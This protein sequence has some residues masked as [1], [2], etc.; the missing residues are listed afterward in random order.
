[1]DRI[2]FKEILKIGPLLLDGAMGTVLH[3]RGMPIDQCFDALNR[4]NPAIVADIHRGYINA[5]SDIIETNSFGANRFKLAQHGLENDVVELNQAAVAVARR[6]IASSFKRILLAGSIGPLG[7]RLAPLGR[8]KAADAEAAFGEQVGALLADSGPDEHEKGVDLIILETMPDLKELA[9]AVSAVRTHSA[10]IP[11]IAM[12]TFT[13]DD[14]TILGDTAAR[15]ATQMS[16]LDVD[17]IGVNCSSGQCKCS[18]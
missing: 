8:V 6:V 9:S 3:G 1:M 14:R 17:A 16:R 11:L 7:V 4:D 18:A 12:M 13:R 15:V 2:A 10:D 5:G